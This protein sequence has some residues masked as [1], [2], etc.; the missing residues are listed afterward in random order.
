[1]Y[2][3]PDKN[4]WTGRI[5][6]KEDINSFRLHQKITCEKV[7]QLAE[8]E[9]DFCIIGFESDEGVRRNKGRRG[10]AKAPNE[11]RK[12]LANLP[13]HTVKGQTIVDTG[14]ISCEGENLEA[15]QEE[16]GQ[17]I[18]EIFSKK[19]TPIII[20]GGHETTYGHYLGARKYIGQNARLGIINIDA[21]FNMRKSDLPSSGTM[22]RQILEQ[23]SKA[24]YLCLGIQPLGNTDALF[25]EADRLG[26]KYVLEEDISIGNFT[27]TSQVI[28]RFFQEHDFIILTLCTDAIS[29]AIAPGVSAPS[30]FGFDQSTVR[31]LLRQIVAHE[32]TM[33]FDISEV[34]PLVDEGDKTSR[35]AAYL[36]AEVL[37]SFNRKK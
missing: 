6:S 9:H 30:P 20:G 34:N 36:I 24:G 7:D 19:A 16:L 4:L 32:K 26:A 12:F 27:Q 35:L 17:H 21:H 28:D 1:M 5:D 31:H 29:S 10:A 33:S 2:N 11:I 15:A 22:F 13:Y 14:N 8:K 18:K 3:L 37:M 25:K 23:D